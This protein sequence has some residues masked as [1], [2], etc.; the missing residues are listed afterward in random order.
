MD[1]A[2]DLGPARL[3][4]GITVAGSNT[5]AYAGWFKGD[6]FRFK[7]FSVGS[8]PHYAVTPH[9]TVTLFDAT[10]AW[11]PVLAANG[12][13]VVLAYTENQD[14]W[15]RISTN[16]GASFGP[17]HRL[18]NLSSSDPNVAYARSVDVIG[19]VV[20]V[21]AT[22]FFGLGGGDSH[23]YDFSSGDTGG[24]WDGG[25]I[26]DHGERVGA[27][28]VVGDLTVTCEAWDQSHSSVTHQHLR[29][30]CP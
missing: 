12:S 14:L 15:V 7:R 13:T 3:D 4:G 5:M 1:Y 25:V 29:A 17:A 16:T 23:E 18:I 21:E 9:P 10:A 26:A 20:M 24:S 6:H 22:E 27:L 11:Q 28:A 30:S 2:V 8:G 19:P